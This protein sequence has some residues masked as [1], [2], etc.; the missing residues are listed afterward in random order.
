MQSAKIDFMVSSANKCL[1]GVPGF[2]YVLARRSELAK[3]KGNAR[4]LSLDL[5]A[6]AEGLDASGQFRCAHVSR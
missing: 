4:S 1:E 3:C 2:G 5:Y 6:Q